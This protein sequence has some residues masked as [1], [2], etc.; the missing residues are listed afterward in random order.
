[1]KAMACSALRR[2]TAVE[3]G[4]LPP[5][6]SFSQAVVSSRRRQ[7]SERWQFLP[8]T[9]TSSCFRAC[10]TNEAESQPPRGVWPKHIYP[11]CPHEMC[12]NE[13]PVPGAFKPWDGPETQ[14]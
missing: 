3:L 11:E 13:F 9:L 5:H 4:T 7:E 12:I 6:Y 8:I 10:V 14:P 1:M 2:K